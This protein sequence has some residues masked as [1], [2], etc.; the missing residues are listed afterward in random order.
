MPYIPDQ[1]NNT[2]SFVQQTPIFD[3]T[4]LYEVEVTSP[5]FKELL[6][7]L[8]QQMNNISL[9]LNQKISGYYLNEEFVTGS[10]FY[11][12]NS[13]NPLELIPEYRSVYDT[14]ALPTGVT[15][16]VA[17]GLTIASTWRFTAIYGT[18]NDN[19]GP[20]YAPI[21]N[22]VVGAGD[23]AISIDGTNINIT[24]NTGTNF[25]SSNVVLQYVKY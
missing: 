14:G 25:T 21:P 17:H 5:E 2:G 19:V 23:I 3:P 24:N 11:N 9:V 7:L 8:A 12:P 13:D 16:I 10:Q 1:L 22:G 18:A 4:R 15:T 20:L 6:V